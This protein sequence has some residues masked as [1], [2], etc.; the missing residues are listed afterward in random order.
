MDAT[1]SD[2]LARLEREMAI[3]RG[4]FAWLRQ[5]LG[6]PPRREDAPPA[7][8]AAPS[9]PPG[10]AAPGTD[11]PK[12]APPP[13]VAAPPRKGPSFEELIGRYG[14][15]AIATITVMVGVGILLNLLIQKKLLVPYA[16][17]FFTMIDCPSLMRDTETP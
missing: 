1:E 3:L 4:E 12:P 14:T 9:P 7:R 6:V 11:L 5:H 13:F 16:P 10:P 15:I 2:R 17:N 8:S